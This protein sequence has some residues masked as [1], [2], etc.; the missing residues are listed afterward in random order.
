MPFIVGVGR[1]GTTLLRLMLDAHPEM[2]I[3]PETH[4]VP[5]MLEAF[6]RPRVSPELVIEAMVSY[7][8]SGWPDSGVSEGEMLERLRA[9]RPLNSTDA[10][11][12]FY[13]AYAERHGKSRFG[14]KTPRYVT[15]LNRIGRGL[16]EAHFIHVIRDG[17]DVALSMNR[18]LVELRG[19]QPV[20]V[21]RLARRWQRRVLNARANEFVADRYA[22]VRYEDLVTD[23]EATLRRVCG[24]IG[25]D[26]DPVMLSYHEHAAERLEEMNRTRERVGR[27]TLSGAERMKAHALTSAPPSSERIAVWKNEMSAADKHDFEVAA[28][29]LLTELGYETEGLAA[30]DGVAS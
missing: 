17:R 20:P 13:R 14:D 9:L 22:E 10:V 27:Q 6:E 2:A 25:L 4:F 23:T 19:S 15:R 3:P 24:L 30:T 26:F 18:R 7:P 29:G 16:P 28:G 11:R 21:R 12:A 1:S 8:R 5:A